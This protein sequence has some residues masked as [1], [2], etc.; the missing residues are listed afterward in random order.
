M[1]LHLLFHHLSSGLRDKAIK[2]THIRIQEQNSRIQIQ[3][4]EAKKQ[5]AISYVLYLV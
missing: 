3:I 2:N 5:G 1:K 4:K